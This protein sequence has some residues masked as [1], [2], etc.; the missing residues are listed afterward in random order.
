MR[1]NL[2]SCRLKAAAII[3]VFIIRWFAF[4]VNKCACPF[5]CFY[6]TIL[7]FCVKTKQKQLFVGS[8]G[9]KIEPSTSMF[10]KKFVNLFWAVSPVSSNR[11]PICIFDLSSRFHC[12][13]LD[14]ALL[15][16]DAVLFFG[17]FCTIPLSVSKRLTFAHAI[18]SFFKRNLPWRCPCIRDKMELE[19]QELNIVSD[20]RHINYILWLQAERNQRE[21]RV[22]GCT[23][24]KR[25]APKSRLMFKR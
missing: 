20:K 21:E 12:L 22:W 18:F 24:L 15:Q 2:L 23:S 1:S 10:A 11:Q 16:A 3:I 14:S 25:T 13:G 6:A 7:L 9:Q 19:H 8:A 5:F 17:Y 4:F